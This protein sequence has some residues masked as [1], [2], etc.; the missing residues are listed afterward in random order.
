L[1]NWD[2]LSTNCNL[3]LDEEFV[4]I[5]S[6]NLNW[7]CL[8]LNDNLSLTPYILEKYN[9]KID[10]MYLQDNN[11][12]MWTEHFFEVNAH[13]WVWLVYFQNTYYKTDNIDILVKGLSTNKMIYNNF[14]KGISRKFINELL[15]EYKNTSY[16]KSYPDSNS[17]P[18]LYLD[19][20]EGNERDDAIKDYND[21]DDYETEK[22]ENRINDTLYESPYYDDESDLDQQDPRFDF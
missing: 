7:S 3:E 2:G 15:S 8:V 1:W 17:N 9:D 13:K 16:S 21:W 14:F 19:C 22:L 20:F 12:I 11:G 10:W 18:E 5:F 6:N 4:D